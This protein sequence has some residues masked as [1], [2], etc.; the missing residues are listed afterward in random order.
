MKNALNIEIT[1]LFFTYVLNISSRLI[2]NESNQFTIL[3]IFIFHAASASGQTKITKDHYYGTPPFQL[4]N[5][6]KQIPFS[7]T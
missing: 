6:G 2:N 1:L 4:G 5:W 3:S 7:K